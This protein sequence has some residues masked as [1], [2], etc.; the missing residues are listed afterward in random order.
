MKRNFKKTISLILAVLMVLGL[1]VVAIAGIVYNRAM[2]K[3]GMGTDFDI[4]GE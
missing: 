1:L 2:E 4:T 3:G